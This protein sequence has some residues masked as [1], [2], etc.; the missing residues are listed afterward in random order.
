[1]IIHH[2]LGLGDHIICNGLVRTLASN[3]PIE[4]FCRSSNFYNVELMYSDNPN[5]VIV[6]ADSDDMAIDIAKNR[7]DY[8]AFGVCL[9]STYSSSQWDKVFYDQAGVDFIH[10]WASFG[11]NKSP[12]QNIVPNDPYAF[13]CN[14]GSDDTNRLDYSKIDSNLL[15]VHSDSGGFFDNIDLIENATEIHCINSAYIHLV[16][17]MN[18][19]ITTKLFYHKFYAMKEFSDFTLRKNWTFI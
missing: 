9:N 15:H 14:K 11:Y 3:G 18:I 16:D 2:H 12:N 13:I 17:R 7:S 4:L 5:I 19:P 1:M 6:I 10:S 8:V